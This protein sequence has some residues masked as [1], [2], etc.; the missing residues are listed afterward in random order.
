M[1]KSGARSRRETAAIAAVAVLH[2][3]VAYLALRPSLIAL[4]APPQTPVMITEI[5]P[6]KPESE[7]E[8]VEAR[9]PR[10]EGAASA[11]NKRARPSEVVAPKSPI[12]LPPPP[13]TAAPVASTG[14]DAS[15]GAAPD[16][17][18]GS[19]SGGEGTGLGSG[20]EGIGTGGGGGTA[21]RWVK[22]RIRNSDYP[23]A[24]SRAEVGGTVIVNFD[25]TTEGRVR[26]CRVVSSSGNADLDGT[27]CR[28]IEKRFR[29][30]PAR[31]A[32][33][34]PVG[35]T[36]AWRQEWWLEPPGSSR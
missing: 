4:P 20:R 29:Y 15:V 16:E 17:G 31:D 6:P 23:D 25:V 33:G 3:A 14:L 9:A 8:P 19:G 11:A 35:S 13:V 24:A 5:S 34:R 18:P 30:K 12:E 2:I 22:G 28:L 7:P 1:Y 21:A 26:N 36:L 27:T 32:T 10:R